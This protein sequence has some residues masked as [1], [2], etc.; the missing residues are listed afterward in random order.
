MIRTNYAYRHING[1]VE[2]FS[3]FAFTE[4]ASKRLCLQMII[5]KCAGICQPFKIENVVFDDK[6]AAKAF[7]RQEMLIIQDDWKSYDNTYNQSR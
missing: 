1:E 2:G 5:A 7:T 4:T 6:E 3:A